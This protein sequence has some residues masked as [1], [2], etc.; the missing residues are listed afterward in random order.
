MSSERKI[1]ISARL[2]SDL[3]DR[4]AFVARNIDNDALATRS[5]VVETALESWLPTAE[6]R[7]RELG[8]SPPKKR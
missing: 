4:V 6:K 7:L 1:M 2:P 8:L 3:V 5:A